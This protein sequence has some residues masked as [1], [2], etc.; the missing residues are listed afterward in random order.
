MTGRWMGLLLL[1]ALPF[2]AMGVEPAAASSPDDRFLEAVGLYTQT[3]YAGAEAIFRSLADDG[4]R[5]GEVY[6]NLGNCLYKQGRIG[7]AVLAYRRAQLDLPRDPDIAANLRFA[8]RT[9]GAPAV[10]HPWYITLAMHLRPGD[11]SRL[12]TAGYWM[13]GLALT[14]MFL[15]P[16]TRTWSLRMALVGGAIAAAG[17]AGWG[18]WKLGERKPEAVVVARGEIRTRYAPMEEATPAFALPEGASVTVEDHADGWVR[19]RAGTDVGW[20]RSNEIHMVAPW[21]TGR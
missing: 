11:W 9:T 8:R 6:F 5:Q 3:N 17:A 7:E 4:Y 16:S 15:R 19:V 12:F 2:R 10:T 13:A 14:A 1:M 18:A 20:A 21:T